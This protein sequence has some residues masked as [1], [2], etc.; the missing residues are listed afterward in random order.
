MHSKPL[1]HCLALALASALPT[2]ADAAGHPDGMTH[3]ISNRALAVAAR[4]AR[5]ADIDDERNRC[6]DTRT[7]AQWLHEVVGNNARIQWRGGKCLLAFPGNPMDAGSK[8]C[9]GATIVPTKDP[10][11]PARIEVYFEQ[12]EKGKP[13]KAYAFRAENFDLDGLDYKRDTRS[14]EIGYGQRF[15][16]G[17]VVT[18]GD[19]D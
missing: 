7:V 17:Y 19:C 3:G 2:P 9:G 1:L 16:D 15:I 6:N 10:Q 8:W 11:H 18:D 12:P 5:L 14:F 13:G 4:N